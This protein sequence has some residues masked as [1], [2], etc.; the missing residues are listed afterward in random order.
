MLPCIAKESEK[1]VKENIEQVHIGNFSLPVSQ[2]PGPLVGFGQ[3]ILDK[4]DLQF[5]VF[6]DQFKGKRKNFVEVAP[7]LLYGIND[8]LSLFIEQAVAAKFKTDTF[9]SHGLEDLLVQLEGVVYAHETISQVSAITLVANMTFPTGSAFKIPPTGFGSPSFFLG[10]TASHTATDWY[11]FT[12][13]AVILTTQRKHTKFGN[14]FWYQFGISKNID[15]K[16]DTWIFNWMVEVDG[17]Y[18]QR[19]KFCGIIDCDSGG[20]IVILGPSLWFSTQRLILQVGISAVI[21]E[22]LF[23]I[24]SPDSYFLAANVGWKF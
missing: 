15:Y 7:S 12:S 20:N 3:N 16:A 24:Q 17:I 9:T 4:G 5:F 13:H 19:N 2:Q 14:Q 8:K 1:W 23:G 21:S 6:P 18:R 22:H 10:F 11:F